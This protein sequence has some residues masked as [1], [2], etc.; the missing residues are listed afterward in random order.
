MDFGIM[1][2]SNFSSMATKILRLPAKQGGFHFGEVQVHNQVALASWIHD[3]QR[4]NMPIIAQD[5]TIEMHDK[6]MS[7]NISAS[8]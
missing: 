2:A 8:Y 6:C 5:F 7:V 4:Q 1:R 3:L